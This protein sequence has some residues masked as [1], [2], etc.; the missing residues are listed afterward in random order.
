MMFK[1]RLKQDD[2]RPMVTQ[3]A[4]N[5]QLINTAEFERLRYYLCSILISGIKDIITVDELLAQLLIKQDINSITRHVSQPPLAYHAMIHS[6]LPM[7]NQLIAN[8]TAW[9]TIDSITTL[10]YQHSLLPTQLTTYC[11]K[12]D[13]Y[14]EQPHIVLI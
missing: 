11:S 13:I 7:L 12:V 14:S 1:H 8:N 3:L 6:N 9:V 4:S 5:R 10:S 2:A